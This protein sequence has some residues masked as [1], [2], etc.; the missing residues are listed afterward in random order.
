M[1]FMETFCVRK[2]WGNM[3]FEFEHS[4]A[5]GKSGGILC[6]WDPLCFHKVNTTKSDSFV[7][8]RGV[9]KATGV[10]LMIVS[11]YAPQETREKQILW[12]YLE[13][14]VNRWEGEVV[15]MGDFNEVRYM[16]ER[17]G[18]IFNASDANVFNS[19][20]ADSGLVEVVLG[21]SKFT[22]CHKSGSKM[23]KL[24]RFLVSENLTNTYPNMNAITM[25]RYL[26][27]HCP[28]FLREIS[29]DYGPIPF[30][31]FHNW[32][33][34]AEFNNLV[35]GVW[36]TYSSKESNPIR[37]FT[38]KLKFLKG[39]IRE[40]NFSQRSADISLYHKLKL[41]LENL[42]EIIDRGEVNDTII[43]KRLDT[44]NSLNDLS[45]S[46]MMEV[47]QKTKIRWAIEGDE[48]SNFFHG[49]LNK[50]RRMLNVRGVLVDGSWIDNPPDVKD[51]FFKHFST[52]FRNPGDKEAY[53]D[54]DFPTVLSDKDR[55][56]IESEVSND[57]IKLAVW[58]CGTDKAPG[59]DGFT[60]GFYRRYWDLIKGDVINA[61]RYFFTHSD[62]PL[63]CNSSFIT[64]IPKNINAKLVKEFRPISLIGSLY[65]IIAK[66]LANRLVSV[67]NDLVNEVQSAFIADRQ[68]LDGPFLL[69]EVIQWC[70]LRKKQMLIFKVDFEKAYDSVRW[71]YL[72][73]ILRKFGFGDKWCK[74]IQCCLKSSRGSILVNGSP[75][76]EFDFG[77]GLKQGDPLSSFL[78]ILVMES[79]HLSFSRV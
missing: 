23:S 15:I 55:Q 59:P 19:F 32:F 18:S 44:L 47:A 64:L 38:R 21:G 72:D 63:G 34:I 25:P 75:T 68:I 4:D 41:D 61:V 27:D 1:E 14:E 56:R 36:K 5:V 26:S 24:D 46:R 57:E 65:K 29:Y 30:K 49:M 52:R 53:I 17:F 40:W 67:I 37:Y 48:N 62:I 73:E 54:M 42:D 51:E 33:D 58:D 79:L 35:E 8:I 28:I 3:S 43:S 9:W 22:W 6:V 16:C 39:K 74:W 12:E 69:N 77:R 20:I 66:I 2:C 10:K 7:M 76:K 71:D 11:V 31:V 78:F 60:F 50:K 13:S 45:N 70:K